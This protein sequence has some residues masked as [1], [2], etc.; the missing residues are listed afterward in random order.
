ML[1]RIVVAVAFVPVIAEGEIESIVPVRSNV[2]LMST[3]SAARAAGARRIVVRVRSKT[4][5]VIRTLP[6]GF[7]AF[8]R[9][10]GMVTGRSCLRPCDRAERTRNRVRS[11]ERTPNK[12][13]NRDE[14]G[15]GKP[16]DELSAR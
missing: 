8:P 12:L 4:A 7:S 11:P 5:I 14:V 6:T 1:V 15:A 16:M 10:C 9:L 13:R 3:P 2:V